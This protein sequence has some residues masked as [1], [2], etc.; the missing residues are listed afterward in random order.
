MTFTNACN[1]GK[2]S[3]H[4]D[5]I[6]NAIALFGYENLVPLVPFSLPEIRNA[7]S[8]GDVHLNTLDIARW[9]EA[10]G[11]RFIRTED[12]ELMVMVASPLTRIYREHGINAYS[13]SEGVSLLKHVALRMLKESGVTQ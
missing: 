12:D 9:D 6:N 13:C 10:A 7:Y 4:T 8:S 1:A 5:T 2:G 3:N 11:F